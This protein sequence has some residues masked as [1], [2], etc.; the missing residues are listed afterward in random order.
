MDVRGTAPVYIPPAYPP[1][2]PADKLSISSMG[3]GTPGLTVPLLPHSSMSGQP[4]TPKERRIG[5]KIRIAFIL[6]GLFVVLQLHPVIAF[7][8]K[9]YGMIVMRPFELANEFGC[10]TM[11]GIVFM[12]IIYFILVLIWLRHL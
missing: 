9:A 12:A 3:V 2:S 6:T 4:Q 5:K 7:L 1:A 11:K 8:D 10:I